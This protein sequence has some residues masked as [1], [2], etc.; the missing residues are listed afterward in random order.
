M[1][2]WRAQARVS[3]PRSE[4]VVVSMVNEAVAGD[5]IESQVRRS[6]K[7]GVREV[8][9]GREAGCSITIRVSLCK[10]SGSR[11]E[12]STMRYRTYLMYVDVYVYVYVYARLLNLGIFATRS[13]KRI[14]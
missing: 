10:L 12:S 4:A 3:F 9:I 8:V 7:A 6:C 14:V 5:V 2:V 11:S 1:P 13:E